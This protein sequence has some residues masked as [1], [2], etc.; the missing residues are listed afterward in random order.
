MPGENEVDLSDFSDMWAEASEAETGGSDT[1]T[2]DI[3]EVLLGLEDESD[4]DAV[5]GEATPAAGEAVEVPEEVWEWSAYADKTVPVKV[6]D[7]E[8]PVSLKE[9]RDGYMRQQD[10]TQKTQLV[11]QQRHLAEWARD[12]QL[13]LESDPQ[14]MIEAMARAFNVEYNGK[15]QVDPLADVD[16]DLRPVYEQ[17]R[18]LQQQLQALMDRQ[19][20]IERERVVDGVRRE[21]DG[22]KGE[23]GEAFDPKET[24]MLAQKYNLDLRTA[25]FTRIGQ[26]YGVK[27]PDPA[28]PVVDTAAAEAAAEASRQAA[29]QAA[30]GTVPQRRLKASEIATDQFNDIGELFELIS[31]G[32]DS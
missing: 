25:H 17:N 18:Q 21:I 13:G 29:K 10:Y 16:E 31:G 14:G 22:L 1:G 30:T 8:T 32:S 26:Q 28:V 15:T 2:T 9:L 6:G 24:L 3:P 7:V 20:Q 5:E 4:T 23:F 19:E 12:I 27:P 11:A